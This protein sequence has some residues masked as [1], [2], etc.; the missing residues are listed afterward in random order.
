MEAAV[1]APHTGSHHAV[2]G[3]ISASTFGSP[4]LLFC[5]GVLLSLPIGAKLAVDARFTHGYVG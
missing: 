4:A 2:S 5:S 1:K 3:G